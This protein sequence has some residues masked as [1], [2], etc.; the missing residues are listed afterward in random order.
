MDEDQPLLWDLFAQS[1]VSPPGP[2][3]PEVQLRAR[4]ITESLRY[5]APNQPMYPYPQDERADAVY[6]TPGKGV[7]GETSN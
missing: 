6:G 5:K 4:E 1:T 3:R 2:P 7:N